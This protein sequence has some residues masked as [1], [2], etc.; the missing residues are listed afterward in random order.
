[1]CNTDFARIMFHYSE[2]QPSYKEFDKEVKF[3]EGL[4]QSSVFSN[5]LQT[6]LIIIDDF[7]R[8]SSSD[9]IVDLFAKGNHHRNLSVFFISQNLFYKGERDISLNVL[10]LVV[11]KNPRDHAQ[12][13]YLARQVY[14]ENSRFIREIFKDATLKPHSYLLFDMI[15]TTCDELR[16]RSRIFPSD[17]HECVYVPKRKYKI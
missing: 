1:M 12:I 4:P 5:N 7:M 2:W 9:V 3:V 15:Q 10:Y 17:E 8:E 6:K 16:F 11:F 14:P 13:Q